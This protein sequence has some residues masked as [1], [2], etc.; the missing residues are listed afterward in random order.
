MG[1]LGRFSDIMS[2]NINAMLDKMEDPAKMVDQYLRNL[3]NDLQEVKKETASIMAEEARVKRQFEEAVKKKNQMMDFAQKAVAAGND[4]DARRFLTEKNAAEKA[5][6]DLEPVY[7]SAKGNAEKMRQMHDKLVG[8]IRE[9]QNKKQSIQ[10]KAAIAKTQ[11]NINKMNEAMTSATGTMSNFDRMEQRA[12]KMLDEA[13]AMAELNL[14][15]TEDSMK[16][17]TEKYSNGVSA[18]GQTVE[19]ELAALKASIGK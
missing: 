6:A 16:D 11:K 18:S 3:E 13:N 8:D 14:S 15:Q 7:Q 9:L 4:D 5:V 12:N 19:D 1:I 10:S 17:L 2:S